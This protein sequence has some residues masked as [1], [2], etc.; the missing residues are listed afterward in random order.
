VIRLSLLR[1]LV[2]ARLTRRANQRHIDIIAKI[3]VAPT[4]KPVAGLF[5][6]GPDFAG[7]RFQF[8]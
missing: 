6:S 5:M 4:G 3:N 7:K 8:I 1:S 2:D